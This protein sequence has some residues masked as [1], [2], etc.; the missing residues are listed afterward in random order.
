MTI[1]VSFFFCGNISKDEFNISS[2]EMQI[3]N[4]TSC[5]MSPT[6]AFTMIFIDVFKLTLFLSDS[7]NRD[8][9]YFS[10]VEQN[11]QITFQS[12]L[13]SL[14]AIKTSLASVKQFVI[15]QML[16]FRFA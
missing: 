3:S 5:I 14:V 2:R 16:F 11:I 8:Q 10:E 7:V 15:L 12:L 1:T 4:F 13:C 9:R 6:P